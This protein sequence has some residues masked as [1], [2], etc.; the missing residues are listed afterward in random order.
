MQTVGFAYLTQPYVDILVWTSDGQQ[1]VF[2]MPVSPH[3]I[4]G[5]TLLPAGNRVY[6]ADRTDYIHHVSG[7]SHRGY[8]VDAD[9]SRGHVISL[10]YAR[11]P[12]DVSRGI[13]PAMTVRKW[14]SVDDCIAD[15][16]RGFFGNGAVPAGMMSIVSEDAE[17]FSRTKARLEDS[18][19]GAENTNSVVYS[20]LPVDPL[21]NSPSAVGK[22][23]WTPFQQANN[24]LDIAALDDVVNRRLANAL[25][26][27][28]IVRGIDNGQ[29]YSN[30]EQAQRTFVEYTL[31]PLLLNIWDKF[32]FELDR[33]TGGLGYDITFDLDV[34]ALTDEAR[35]RAEIQQ[36]QTSS[37]LSLVQAGV[38]AAQA[39]KV[40]DLP[41]E[42]A[43]LEFASTSAGDVVVATGLSSAAEVAERVAANT[44]PMQA[45]GVDDEVAEVADLLTAR[46]ANPSAGNEQ[47][48]EERLQA[49]A[50][51][52]LQALADGALGGR[53]VRNEVRLSSDEMSR[54][55]LAACEAY[56]LSVSDDER[57]RLLEE[58][59]VGKADL[60]E[61]VNSPVSWET[62]PDLVQKDLL[63]HLERVLSAWLDGAQTDFSQMLAENEDEDTL[64][65]VVAAYIAG[66]KASTLVETELVTLANMVSFDVARELEDVY[67]VT[68][69]KVWKHSGSDAPCE[70]CASMIDTKLPL[71]QTYMPVGGVK[72]IGESIYTNTY[73]DMMTPPAH[74]HCHCY[75]RIV[76]EG[77]DV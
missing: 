11:H 77:A 13:A 44:E 1:A 31:R 20:M 70:F 52:W 7:V 21:T 74:P 16:E 36:T 63:E 19:R 71:A 14:A 9:I 26:V 65:A 28:D 22:L 30:A 3:N 34:P 18:F 39:A 25:A 73:E 45:E 6:R 60:V 12:L 49:L 35:A 2:D 29:T 48:V 23:S 5:Y 56:L 68:F 41:E 57:A 61:Q 8:V 72:A 17:D 40:L 27:P 10:S 37:F 47:P 33:L 32:K 55:W 69:T 24:T 59:Q 43:G 4:V 53:F 76:L 51:S 64:A 62:L 42:W 58:I 67:G 38:S 15:Y 54:E 46:F 50:V 66:G 75:S